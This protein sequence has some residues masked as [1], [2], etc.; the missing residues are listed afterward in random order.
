MYGM[1][2]TFDQFDP[3]QHLFVSEY[4]AKGGDAGNGT[5]NAALAEAVFMNGLE[6]NSHVIQMASY[7]PLFANANNLAWIP[8]SIYFTSSEV[9][10]TPSYWDQVLYSNS[11]VGLQS[12]PLTVQFTV[13][14]ATDFSAS[15]TVGTLTSAYSKQKNG[16][17]IVYIFKLVNHGASTSTITIDLQGLSKSA[18]FPAMSDLGVL[19]SPTANPG[20]LNSFV[21]PREIAPAY[22]TLNIN[23]PTYTF[24]LPAYSLSVLRIYILLP[25][26]AIQAS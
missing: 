12:P 7:A 20:D 22:S 16:A 3:N 13:G 9:Y 14:G 23:S 1:G 11:F 25:S 4:A 10:G 8:D 17:N 18:T 24:D 19:H 6:V 26:A 21:H 2:Q 15:V 5:L